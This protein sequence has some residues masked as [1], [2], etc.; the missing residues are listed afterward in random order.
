MTSVQTLCVLLGSY[1]RGG[2]FS[3]TPMHTG[4]VAFQSL[5]MDV[6]STNISYEG[7]ESCP[8]YNE[9]SGVEFPSDCPVIILMSV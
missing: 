6:Y 3:M 8:R 9:S 7:P 2:G 4:L 5:L 1:M